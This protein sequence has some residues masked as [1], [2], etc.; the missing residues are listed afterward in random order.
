MAT[1][2]TTTASVSSS[3][4]GVQAKLIGDA[5]LDNYVS[6]ADAVA[7]LQY[8]GNK[9]KYPFNDTQKANADVSGNGDGI[10]PNDALTIQKVDAGMYK[11]TDLPIR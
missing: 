7:I 6:V 10:T 2:T 11:S 5:N 1:T 3:T 8:I 9:D 4:S